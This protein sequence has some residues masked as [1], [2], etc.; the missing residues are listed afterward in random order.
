GNPPLH[1]FR[2]GL[3]FALSGHRDFDGMIARHAQLAR[4]LAEQLELPVAVQEAVG[5]SYEQWDGKGWPGNLSGEAVPI[6]ARISQLAEFVEV[7]HRVG[8][9]DAARALASRRAG[10]QFD[11][12]L[13]TTLCNDGDR[14]FADLDGAPTWDTVIAAEPALGVYLHGEQFDAALIAIAD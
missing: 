6:A 9:I 11:P 12:N 3:E 4:G 14:I 13:C 7:A 2:I 1:R 10:G 5:A 8:G